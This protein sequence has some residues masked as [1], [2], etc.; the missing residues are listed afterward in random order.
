MAGEWPPQRRCG[1]SSP[2]WYGPAFYRRN[3]LTPG[4]NQQLFFCWWGIEA[5]REKMTTRRSH[6][7]PRARWEPFGSLLGLFSTTTISKRL[8]SISVYHDN[9]RW[10]L[11][12]FVRFFSQQ[13]LLTHR[14]DLGF[15]NEPA[16]SA[17]SRRQPRLTKVIPKGTVSSGRTKT[18]NP[19]ILLYYPSTPTQKK[20]MGQ[21]GLNWFW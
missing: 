9:D 2:T 5:Q 13:H 3:W 10:V 4:R 8:R 7:L 15:K 16:A 11:G 20:E 21:K 19:I 6:S 17:T 12:P 18:P 1:P 14:P